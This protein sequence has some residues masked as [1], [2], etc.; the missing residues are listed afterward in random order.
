VSE[1]ADDGVPV[2]VTCRVLKIARQH[3]YRWLARPVSDAEMTEAYRSNYGSD[4]LRPCC[5][6]GAVGACL[7]ERVS[8]L[9]GVEVLQS[10][11][12]PVTQRGVAGI[13]LFGEEW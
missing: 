9:G 5:W 3:Y 12:G 2:A 4:T 8:R 7:V 13:E 1:L 11:D 10:A 6:S